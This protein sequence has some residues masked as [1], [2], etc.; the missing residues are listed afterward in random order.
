MPW[1]AKD[2]KK[3]GAK[4][5]FPQAAAQANAILRESGDEGMALATAMKHVNKP[6]ACKKARRR[7]P[8]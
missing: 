4:R 5:M 7:F 8:Q 2:M 6:G 3:K 1:N